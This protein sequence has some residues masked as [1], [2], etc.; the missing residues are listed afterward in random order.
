MF[1]LYQGRVW[2]FEQKFSVHRIR[3]SLIL[4]IFL[5]IIFS[6]NFLFF[7]TLIILVQI[8]LL[9]VFLRQI[10]NRMGREVCILAKMIQILD[11][12]QIFVVYCFTD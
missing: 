3:I 2:L 8:G 1:E 11:R 9:K 5:E 10:Y 4:I 6:F 7:P 12:H